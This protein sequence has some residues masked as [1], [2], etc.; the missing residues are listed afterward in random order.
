[1]AKRAYA[2][3]KESDYKRLGKKL[4]EYLHTQD[5]NEAEYVN[6]PKQV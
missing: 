5:T 3:K 2:T 6:N 1:M 4:F